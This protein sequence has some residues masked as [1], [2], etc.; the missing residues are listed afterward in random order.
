L[1]ANHVELETALKA[2]IADDV[3][4]NFK[5]IRAL[6]TSIILVI[7]VPSNFD[8]QNKAEGIA[9][10]LFTVVCIRDAKPSSSECLVLDT[11]D[12]LC[13]II[14][15]KKRRRRRKRRK[16]RRIEIV[17]KRLS[18]TGDDRTFQIAA[19]LKAATD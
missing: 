7:E 5:Y 6:F 15:I 11:I 13:K 16:R 9:S 8:A 1:F 19:I 10:R 3:M 17:K 2:Q 14:V 18:S 12:A 4:N